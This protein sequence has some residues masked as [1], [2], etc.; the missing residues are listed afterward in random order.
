MIKKKLIVSGDSWTGGSKYLQPD[1]Y[2]YWPEIL[3][4]K[5]NMI[6]VNVA[7]GGMGNEFIYSSVIDK[8][9]TN[10]NIGLTICM[11]SD[12]DRLDF[13]GRGLR[14]YPNFIRGQFHQLHKSMRYI[15]AFQ[16]HCELNKIPF[17]QTQG[18]FPTQ[19]CDKEFL[20][21][22]QFDLIDGKKFIG[23]PMYRELGG[24]TMWN[25]LDKVDPEQVKLRVSKDDSHP[26]EQGH[27]YIAEIIY[28]HYRELYENS[29]SKSK[30]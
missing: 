19:E 7:K 29:I 27:E 1:P 23:W 24:R 2:P 12:F 16:N 9:C 17:L 5:L 25:E 11:W 3:A 28:K 20:D 22:A 10:K 21:S 30:R 4:D 18:I 13:F 15:H 14:V 8:L 6:C 26:N